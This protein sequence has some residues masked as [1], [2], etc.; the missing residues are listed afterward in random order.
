MS[1]PW[2]WLKPMYSRD[3]KEHHRVATPL[4]LLFDLIFVVAI[5]TAGQELHHAIIENHFFGALPLYAMVFFAL[6][7]AWMNFTWFA[8]AYDNDD[9]LYR[10]MTMIQMIGALVIAAGIPDAF[11]HHDFDIIIVGYVVM[12]TVLIFQWLRAARHDPERKPTIYRYVIGIG[13]IQIAWMFFH[14]AP[15]DFGAYIFL[16]LVLAELS[17]PFVAEKKGTTPWHP[18]HIVERYSLLTIIVFGESIVGSFKAISDALK[19]QVINTE[20]VF[21]TIGGVIMMFTMWW[22]Y[23]DRSVHDQLNNHKNTFVWG[24]GHFLIFISI[25]LLGAA[26]AAA[27]DVITLHAEVSNAYDGCIIAG[28]L[29]L[30]TCSLWLLHERKFLTGAGRWFYPISVF[31]I[32][33]IPFLISHIGYAVLSMA[34]VYALR[35]V[36]SKWLIKSA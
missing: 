10:I 30:Y 13:I 25:A 35:L 12:R 11:E 7:W 34:L 24:Y 17:V 23:F 18:H 29:I 4:E 5:A 1:S 26:L 28:A 20:L 31:I 6:W 33:A 21:L 16:V 27:A 2:Q 15:V 9:A 8:S 32:L 19:T 3:T 14:F 22:A 36:L